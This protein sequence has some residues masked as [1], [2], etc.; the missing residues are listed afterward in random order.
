[1]RATSIIFRRELAAYLRVAGRLC[2]RGASPARVRHPVPA[3]RWAKASCS[4]P[5]CCSA[6]SSSPR[7]DRGHGHRAQHPAS[8]PR[9]ARLNTM[10]LLNTSPGGTPRSSSEVPAA[11]VF[12]CAHGAFCRSTCRVIQVNGKITTS[13]VA[14]RIPRLFLIGSSVRC[15]SASSKLAGQAQA[16]G[17]RL[18]A[19]LA[20]IMFLLYELVRIC[21]PAVHGPQGPRTGNAHFQTTSCRSVQPEGPRVLRG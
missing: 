18:G 5:W 13:Q 1:M 6:S 9:S 20:G 16:G 7:H 8:S 11:F 15:P 17:G 21:R 12:L 4:A 2:D 14:G 3:R 19:A 10:I